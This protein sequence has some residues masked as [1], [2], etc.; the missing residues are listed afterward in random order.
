MDA[1]FEA[2]KSY[3]ESYDEQRRFESKHACVEFL[4]TIR[5]VEKYLRPGMR[6]LE[7]GAG[8]GR[9][10]RY[11]AA[12]G[13]AVDAIELMPCNI[14]EFKRLLQPGERIR[15][16]QGNAVCLPLE[17]EEI[18][19]IVLLLGPMYH[20]FDRE[21]QKRAISEALRVA[22][23]GAVIFCAYCCADAAI[24][25]AGFIRGRVRRLIEDKMLDPDTFRTHSDPK[26]IFE[27]Y[28]KEDIDA[29]MANFDVVRLH[30]VGTDLTAHYLRDTIDNMD[31]ETFDL[32]MKYHY[33]VCE[34][35]DL[36][37]I[38]NHSLDIF[39]KR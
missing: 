15:I 38:T 32:Y 19:D 25:Q 7:I 37:G 22:K 31:E 17:E 34:R 6:L 33:S 3:Y 24:L 30:Y 26:D 5:Y 11:F 2:L 18:Y 13:Y 29:L 35:E 28:R 16:M 9:Y 1:V 10:S 12:K 14:E 36:V 4:T 8:T 39:K 20:L 27:L 21:D 23:R